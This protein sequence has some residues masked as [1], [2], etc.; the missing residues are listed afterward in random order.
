MLKP[1]DEGNNFFATAH[2]PNPSYTTLDAGNITLNEYLQGE[3][4]GPAYMNNVIL[5]PGMNNVTLKANIS[6][7]PVLA[8]VNKQPYCNDG[9][10][11]FD[12]EA[13]KVVN[14]G[15]SLDYF[16]EAL[17]QTNVTAWVPLKDAISDASGG[18]LSVKCS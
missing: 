11:P 15:S 7:Q 13:I 4:V 18:M 2:L 5:S 12:M 14:D 17:G 9:Q 3:Y 6:Q 8:A 16:Q 10:L 1:D